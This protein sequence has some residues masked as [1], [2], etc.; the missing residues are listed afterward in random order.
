MSFILSLA[1]LFAL[2]LTTSAMAA[3]AQAGFDFMSLLPILAIFVIF[4]FLVLK[5]Q[6]KKAKEH[7]KMLSDLKRGDR[8]VTSGGIIGTIHRV[9]DG[10]EVSL[11]IAEGVRV[12]VL[13]SMVSTILGKTEPEVLKAA[14]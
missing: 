12:R 1:A 6:Q 11:E 4:Y 7:Q 10:Q 3:P 8:V 9:V 2:T 14:S 13:K 5:P